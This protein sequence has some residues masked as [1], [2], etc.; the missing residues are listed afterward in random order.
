MKIDEWKN[1]RILL[2]DDEVEFVKVLEFELKQAG[3][4][5]FKAYDGREALEKMDCNPDLILADILMPGIDGYELCRRVQ[6]DPQRRGIPFIFLTA[7]KSPENRIEGMALGAQKY[8]TKPCDKKELLNAVNMRLKQSEESKELLGKKA[9]AV[10]GNL[11]KVSIFTLFELFYVGKWSGKIE[12]ESEGK[13][14][15]IRFHEGILAGAEMGSEKDEEALREIFTLES[16]EFK[17]E[18]EL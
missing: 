18:R 10:S 7:L 11:E 4:E 9:R 5:V 3:Y 8:L 14:G 15:S 6:A 12:I 13:R 16:G 17:A 2:V 1:K